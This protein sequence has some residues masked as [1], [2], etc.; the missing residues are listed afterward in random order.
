MQV[1]CPFCQHRIVVHGAKPG[2][3]HPPCPKCREKFIMV[4][5][6]VEGHR[7]VLVGQSMQSL[8]PAKSPTPIHTLAQPPEYD[9]TDEA[10]HYEE[11]A[12]RSQ[13]GMV[14]ITE[15][16]TPT[17]D[18]PTLAGAPLP[19]SAEQAAI[20]TQPAEPSDIAAAIAAE[21]EEKTH[22]SV[23]PDAPAP[24]PAAL[25]DDDLAAPTQTFA[26]GHVLQAEATQDQPISPRLP[27]TNDDRKAT[28][29]HTADAPPAPARPAGAATAALTGRLAGYEIEKPIGEG[30]MGAVYLARQLS[31]DRDVAIKTIKP[32]WA[33]NPMFLSRFTREAY[34]A[35]QLAHHN[36]VQIY[37]IGEDRKTHF[38]SMEYV[39]GHSLSQLLRH[40]GPMDVEQAAG[41]IL[42]AARGLKFAHDHDM[43]HR[44]IKPGNLLINDQGVV[45]VADLGL[46][47]TAGDSG[48]HPR[49]DKVGKGKQP[50]GDVF[51]TAEAAMGTPAYMAPEQSQDAAHV[52]GRADIYALGCTFY[53]MTTGRPLF[54]GSTAAELITKHATAP[55]I[56]P[57]R[58][59]QR[60]PK[61]ISA[62]IMKMVAKKPNDRYANMDELIA[63]LEDFL[64]ISAGPFTPREEHARALEE[65]VHAFNDSTRARIRRWLT[66]GF[67]ALC[68]GLFLLGTLTAKPMLAAGAATLWLFTGVGYAILTG[69]TQ[70][71]HLF[72]KLR[73][74]VFGSRPP[75]WIAWGAGRFISTP[76]DHPSRSALGC[77][78]D[79]DRR[80]RAGCRVPF[81]H[82]PACRCRTPAPSHRHPRHAQIHAPARL[83]GRRT[84]PFRLQVQRQTMGGFL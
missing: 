68:I 80:H 40:E 53:A 61:S 60:V 13:A 5:A 24:I 67:T 39:N 45:K 82:R 10:E 65:A 58:I 43:V 33:S 57:E 22:T 3:Y 63:V 14:A 34:A 74:L 9:S 46:V 23:R 44:D 54:E 20:D 26:A 48:A 16:H 37:D 70:R 15:D 7:L 55:V 77:P 27:S 72:R 42:Q 41:Y 76:A 29:D 12:Q 66:L 30:G 50:Q 6:M 31:L 19:E 84:A 51:A 18:F 56:P 73:Q 62:I 52:D 11:E 47:K 36:V 35:A 64:G 83:G 59:I 81:H 38:F 17:S 1:R 71:T 2:G 78:L 8:T 75:E 49:S 32:E 28:L 21:L 4:V 79:S 69:I 25:A